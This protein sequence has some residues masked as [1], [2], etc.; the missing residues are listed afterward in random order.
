MRILLAEDE[1]VTLIKLEALL[2]DWGYDVICAADGDQAWA[3]L[4]ANSELDLVISDVQMP[5]MHG[6][7]FCRQA[8]A[9]LPDRSLYVILLTAIRVT[10]PDRIAGLLAGADDYLHKPC[11]PEE[12]NARLEVGRRVLNLQRELRTRVQQLETLMAS[13]K[14]LR[15]LLPICAY[16]KKIRDDRNY[17]RQIEEYVSAHTDA[18]F[19]HGICP[20]CLDAVRTEALRTKP[21]EG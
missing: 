4:E 14:Q 11:D 5:G 12:L 10:R 9:R 15:G 7:E 17:W 20:A 18:R 13:V 8:R 21:T 2:K 16:C 19:S 6:D 3:A 1:P